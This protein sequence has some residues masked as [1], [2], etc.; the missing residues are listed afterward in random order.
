LLSGGLHH[1]LLPEFLPMFCRWILWMKRDMEI[2]RVP[3]H[4]GWSGLFLGEIG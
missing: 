2:N 3:F 4:R 1:M